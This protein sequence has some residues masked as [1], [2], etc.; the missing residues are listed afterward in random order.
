MAPILLPLHIV[1]C[2]ITEPSCLATMSSLLSLRKQTMSPQRGPLVTSLWP[3]IVRVKF[4]PDICL[5]FP[6]LLELAPRALFGKG[7]QPSNTARNQSMPVQINNIKYFHFNQ[8]Y[9]NLTS[10][11][12]G[13]LSLNFQGRPVFWNLRSVFRK[14]AAL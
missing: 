13:K 8:A 11:V 6:L 5:T 14:S 10:L 9:H 1:G 3:I 7:S 4:Y 12:T 2:T